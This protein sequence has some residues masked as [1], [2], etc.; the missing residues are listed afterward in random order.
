[1]YEQI[2]RLS[3]LAPLLGF[4]ASARHLSF[5]LAASELGLTPSTLSRQMQML[6]EQLGRPL[7]IRKTRQLLLTA[8]GESLLLSLQDILRQ[9]TAAVGSLSNNERRPV[10]ISTSVGFASLWLVPRLSRFLGE[11]PQID[12]R[13]SANNR[14]VDIA[15]E[16]IDLALRYVPREQR[17]AP[18]TRLAGEEIFPVATAKVLGELA[19]RPPRAEDI[20]QLTLLNYD[21]PRPDPWLEWATWL[22]KLGLAG[23]KAKAILHFNHYDQLIAAA[24]AGQG[25]ALGRSALVEPLLASGRLQAMHSP[26]RH[27]SERSYY[28]IEAGGQPR[29]EVQQLCDWLR[30][31]FRNAARP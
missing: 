28:L 31:E 24:A 14:L 26:Y 10:T 5:T 23:V 22:K 29:P 6:E 19:S 1:M 20:R 15:R 2:R 30:S 25:L 21:D 12:V 9:L 3:C 7:F 16:G 4:E 11:H 13:I 27:L 8:E 18:S 17:P